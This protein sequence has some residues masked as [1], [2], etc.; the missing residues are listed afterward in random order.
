[1]TLPNNEEKK[2]SAN[3]TPQ[4]IETLWADLMNGEANKGHRAMRILLADPKQGLAVFQD[5]LKPV[6]PV[7]PQKLA[8]LVA[9]LDSNQFAARKKATDELEK[10]GDLAEASL[11]E[12]LN[13][14]PSPEVKQRVDAMLQKLDGSVL[15][16]ERLRSAR[17]IAA[18]EQ[19]GTADARQVLSKMAEGVPAALA[20][21]EAKAALERI[22]KRAAKP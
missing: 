7:D 9:D 5:R 16:D 6:Q 17:A 2:E 8:K 21:K 1:M 14:K 11:R 18:L 13:G 19:M 12:V 15:T 4:A 3:L 10:L 20:T 22:E